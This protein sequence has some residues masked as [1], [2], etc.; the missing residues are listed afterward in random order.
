[1]F[2]NYTQ[3]DQEFKHSFFKK[4]INKHE[5]D[6]LMNQLSKKVW[7]KEKFGQLLIL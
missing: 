4:P 7:L 5:R 6:S 3:I 2:R 1:M